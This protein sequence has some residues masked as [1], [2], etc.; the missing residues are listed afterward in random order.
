MMVDISEMSREELR[1]AREAKAAELRELEKA[2]ANYNVRRLDEL[3]AEIE[4]RLKSE[5]FAWSD[6]FGSG[7]RKSG[8]RNAPSTPKY[9]H[10]ENP[11]KTWTGRGR[12]PG[13]FKE[14]IEAGGTP[15]DMAV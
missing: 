7:S 10:P 3:K 1:A 8:R 15:E 6:M 13:W 2:E 11:E 9:R 4:E 14:A 12:Q 5:G